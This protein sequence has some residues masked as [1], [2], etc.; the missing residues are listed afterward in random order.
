MGLRID[1]V[2]LDAIAVYA[3]VLLNII[4]IFAIEEHLGIVSYKYIATI[5]VVMV[6]L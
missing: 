6:R 4:F 2:S 3:S 5:S 1:D